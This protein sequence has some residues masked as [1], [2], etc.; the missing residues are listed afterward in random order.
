MNGFIF[1]TE[2]CVGCHACVV[3]CSVENNPEPGYM[4]RSV[5][6]ANQPG[7]SLLPVFFLS[8]AC[9]HCESPSCLSACPAG[10]Y[11]LDSVSGVVVLD[12]DRCIGCKYCTWACPYDAPKYN[13]VS[14]TVQKCTLCLETSLK[15]GYSPA[16]ARNC[17]VGALEFGPVEELPE[18]DELHPLL[19]MSGNKPRVRFVKERLETKPEI[20]PEPVT[21]ECVKEAL[22]GSA[23][24]DHKVSLRNEWS[25]YL[26]SLLVPVVVG[27]F[28]GILSDLVFLNPLY[29]ILLMVGVLSVS[30][31]HLGKKLRAVYA[32]RNLRS[33]WLSRE[34]FAYLLFF[35]L[36]S[37]YIAFPENTL[38]LG[39]AGLFSGFFC[40]YT[41]DR[42]YGF[43]KTGSRW[44]LHSSQAVFSGLLWVSLIWQDPGPFFFMIAIKAILYIFRF[45]ELWKSQGLAAKS[46]GLI[47]LVLLIIIPACMIEV[48][49]LSILATFLPLLPGELLDRAGFYNE[50]YVPS[51]ERKARELLKTVDL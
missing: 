35:I 51:P 21:K 48:F 38:W 22:S 50:S 3:A 37:I 17:P 43:L 27:L 31:F 11:T 49:H 41:I 36:S 13:P 10:A 12:Q 8:M 25:L 5:T 19:P 1:H 29:Y 4:W 47:R 14:H 26:F 2:K 20:I 40:L 24:T 30:I 9:N 28:A 18:A 6:T 16:C 42:V 45:T 15:E 46:L 23:E 32:L 33:S 39:Y 34:I 44:P 7:Y